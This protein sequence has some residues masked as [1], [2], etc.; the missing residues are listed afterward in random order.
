MAPLN[1]SMQKGRRMNGGLYLLG[2]GFWDKLKSFGKKALSVIQ[3]LAGVVKPLAQNLLNAHGDKLLDLG[4]K[5]VVSGVDKLA[6]KS[7][8]ATIQ[9]LADKA[10][11]QIQSDLAQNLGKNLIKRLAEH[12][13][14]GNGLRGLG[15]RGLG[16]RGGM[17]DHVFKQ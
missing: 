9:N 3:P 2:N 14:D 17:Q 1:R 7:G 16:I 5:A 4:T 11:V 6:Q 12:G 8:N 15:L 10:N 13:Q